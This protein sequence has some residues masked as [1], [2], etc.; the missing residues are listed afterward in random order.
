[1]VQWVKNLLWLSALVNQLVSVEAVGQSQAQHSGLRIG[2]FYSVGCRA[3]SDAIPDPGSI[4]CGGGQKRKKKNMNAVTQ[5]I[6]E[7]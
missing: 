6:A 7:V 5:V 1:M 3:S 4:C 2:H